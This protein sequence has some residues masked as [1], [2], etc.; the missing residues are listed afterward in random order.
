MDCDVQEL[1]TGATQTSTN[2]EALKKRVALM[3]DVF[4]HAELWE[5]RIE[6][7]GINQ[8]IAPMRGKWEQTTTKLYGF[9]S[10]IE[11]FRSQL[12]STTQELDN[13]LTI[14]ETLLRK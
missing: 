7:Q 13:K 3:E 4:V 11:N 5:I 9:D 2:L 1:R 8:E 12:Q 14:D 6:L 10:E